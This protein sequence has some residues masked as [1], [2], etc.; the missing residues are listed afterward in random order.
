MPITS[1]LAQV[2]GA[3]FVPADKKNPPALTG[4]F[5]QSALAKSQIFL[6]VIT[7][8]GHLVLD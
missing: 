5:D 3:E 7:N 4:G 8:A 1:D 6:P 2:T